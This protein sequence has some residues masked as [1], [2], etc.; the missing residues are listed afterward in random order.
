MN[1]RDSS[2]SLSSEDHVVVVTDSKPKNGTRPRAAEVQRRKSQL[3]METQLK[4]RS[5]NKLKRL[6]EKNGACNVLHHNVPRR[7]DFLRDGFTTLLDLKWRWVLIIFSFVYLIGWVI[8][9]AF[10]YALVW[11]HGD[12]DY[13][14]R[15]DDR[16]DWEPCVS[17]VDNFISAFLFSLETQTT[18]G[19][20]FRSVTEACW[21]GGTMVVIQSVFSCLVDAVMIGCIFAKLARPKKRAAT[22]KFSKNATISERDGQLCFMFRVGDIRESHIYDTKIRAQLIKPR[23]TSEGECI[24]IET[25][26]LALGPEALP[27]EQIFLV[28]PMIICHVID[29]NSPFYEIGASM[30]R[31]ETFEVIVIL[32]GVL[33]QTGLIMQ[34]RTS[35]LPSEILWGHRFS[36]KFITPHDDHE[37]LTVDYREFNTTYQVHGAFSC[38]AK[39]RDVLTSQGLDIKNMN[40]QTLRSA[41]KKSYSFEDSQRQKQVNGGSHRGNGK[42]NICFVDDIQ[43][44]E[45]GDIGSQIIMSIDEHINDPGFS[46]SVD[47]TKEGPVAI[48][49]FKEIGSPV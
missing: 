42:G 17:N 6:V 27:A 9:A 12:L 36:S 24:P 44:Q 14:D 28:W 16:P 40:P 15:L 38:S 49:P 45:E 26:K 35:Y 2:N 7:G 25:Y 1:G 33:E 37:H 18:I 47:E 29:E 32:E 3:C 5:E 31:E 41:L 23:V 34:A 4:L 46:E 19:Y 20:G 11:D 22:I 8:F 21:L 39:E 30:L 10:W 13:R 43:E 48:V